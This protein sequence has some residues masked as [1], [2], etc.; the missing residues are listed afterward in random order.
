MGTLS[1][2]LFMIFISFV[3]R[4]DAK[5]MASQGPPVV[6]YIGIRGTVLGLD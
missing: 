6:I 5:Q 1:G 2:K 4:W 3:S